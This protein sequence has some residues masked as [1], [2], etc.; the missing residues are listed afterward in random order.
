M[1][2]TGEG[3][4]AAEAEAPTGIAA[5]KSVLMDG[6][7]IAE[8]MMTGNTITRVG[9]AGIEAPA[10]DIEESV[11][12]APEEGGTAARSGKAVRRDVPKLSNGTGNGSSKKL[13]PKLIQILVTITMK[14]VPMGIWNMVVSDMDISNSHRSKET[15]KTDVF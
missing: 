8:G 4:A 15:T 9:V 2:D 10:L 12:E 6:M 1:A 3:V 11:A 7:V 13:L 14:V 5:M